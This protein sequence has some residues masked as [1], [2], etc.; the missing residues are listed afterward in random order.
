VGEWLGIPES[1]A[2]KLL[3]STFFT[4]MLIDFSIVILKN[5]ITIQNSEKARQSDE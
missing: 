1:K 2:M 3:I 4:I 5:R